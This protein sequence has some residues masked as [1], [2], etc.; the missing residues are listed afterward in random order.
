MLVDNNRLCSICLQHGREHS[1]HAQEPLCIHD[2]HIQEKSALGA[3]TESEVD[4]R[5]A[6]LFLF[7]QGRVLEIPQIPCDDGNEV[8]PCVHGGKVQ[9]PESIHAQPPGQLLLRPVQRIPINERDIG[10]LR[11]ALGE[12]LAVGKLFF[13]RAAV[14]TV[15]RRIGR[16]ESCSSSASIAARNASAAALS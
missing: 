4:R 15:A 11:E 9:I 10:R 13:V 7:V 12:L 1:E 16:D 8:L 14:V 3:V 5:H 2:H 6:V